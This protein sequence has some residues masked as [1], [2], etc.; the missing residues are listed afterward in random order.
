M[1]ETVSEI[2]SYDKMYNNKKTSRKKYYH[3]IENKETKKNIK[4]IIIKTGSIYEGELNNRDERHGFGIYKVV[5]GGRYEGNWENGQRNGYGKFFHKSG[6]CIYDGNWKN[7]VYDG[8]GILK[9]R[10]GNLIFKGNF[11]N[12]KKLIKKKKK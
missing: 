3:F 4:K 8:K 9:D 2:V 5:F 12:G 11:K 7:G 10:K 1:Q 6:S